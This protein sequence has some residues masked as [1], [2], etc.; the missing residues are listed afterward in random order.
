[1]ICDLYAFPRSYIF[2]CEI[3]EHAQHFQ[4][5]F[6]F[7]FSVV[8]LKRVK[9]LMKRGGTQII[10]HMKKMIEKSQLVDE[11]TQEEKGETAVFLFCVLW[12]FVLNGDSGGYTSTPFAIY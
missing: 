10:E 1:M 12:F 3:C 2:S 6:H 7:Y 8:G 4:H 9:V 5:F 11:Q